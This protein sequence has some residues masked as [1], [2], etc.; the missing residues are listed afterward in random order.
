M[1]YLSVLIPIAILVLSSCEGQYEV[2]TKLNNDG[3]L[4]RTI[5]YESEEVLRPKESLFGVSDEEWDYEFLDEDSSND[6]PPRIKLFREFRSIDAANT[7]MN[8]DTDTLWQIEASLNSR[9]RWFYTYH[10]FSETYSAIDRLRFVEQKDFFTKEDYQFI[11]RIQSETISSAD[12]LY[13]DLLENKML[14]HY[15]SNSLK[16]EWKKALSDL[17][18]ENSLHNWTDSVNMI[19]SKV[20][21]EGVEDTG[22]KVI[23]LLTKLEVPIDSID[24]VTLNEKYMKEATSKLRFVEKVFG[25]DGLIHHMELPGAIVKSNAHY[26]DGNTATWNS[27]RISYCLTPLHMYAT[28]RT[29]NWWAIAMSGLFLLGTLWWFFRKK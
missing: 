16:S 2:T 21:I 20:E 7:V 5:I 6:L 10:D 25:L 1:K 18:V 27:R 3:S 14:E 26:V 9:F 13:L 8:Q 17:F 28:Y 15:Y 23:K 4:E 12:S 22:K 11:E 19:I 29:P 24:L